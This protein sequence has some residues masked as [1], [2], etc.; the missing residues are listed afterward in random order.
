MD[1]A[2]KEALIAAIKAWLELSRFFYFAFPVEQNLG[3]QW[4]FVNSLLLKDISRGSGDISF[5]A[6]NSD[7]HRLYGSTLYANRSML[8]ELFSLKLVELGHLKGDSP[9]KLIRHVYDIDL[10]RKSSSGNKS[11]HDVSGY[12]KYFH[13]EISARTSIYLTQKFYSS[14]SEYISRSR[15]YY[16]GGSVDNGNDS[17]SISIMRDLYDFG[18]GPYMTSWEALLKQLCAA[19]IN[20]GQSAES[21]EAILFKNTEVYII[22][23][24]LWVRYLEGNDQAGFSEIQIH[25]HHSVI[26]PA[27]LAK[28]EGYLNDIR[29]KSTL[30]RKIRHGGRQYFQIDPKYLYIFDEFAN[31]FSRLFEQFKTILSATPSQ[32][33][34]GHLLS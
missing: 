34:P 32:G 29:S 10:F 25:G 7:M 31:T 26:R 5:S 33:K 14:V 18:R 20:P 15:K 9:D 30:I 2:D 28:I 17:L 11:D 21:L 4:L 27:S 13:G 1:V 6:V 12:S 19:S 3:F 16:L 23:H 24:N 8:I 22:I